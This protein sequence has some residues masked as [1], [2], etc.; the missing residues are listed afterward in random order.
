MYYFRLV[1]ILL[2]V[3]FGLSFFPQKWVIGIKK[4][5]QS[6]RCL[7]DKNLLI[8]SVIATVC[9]MLA[10]HMYAYLNGPLL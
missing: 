5:L 4:R 6:I 9:F 8:T 10:A 3:I 7:I 2:F 1:F